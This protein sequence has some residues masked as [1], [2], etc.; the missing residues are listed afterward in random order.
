MKD[1][2]PDKEV[3]RQLERETDRLRG[4]DEFFALKLSIIFSSSRTAQA[5]RQ[6]KEL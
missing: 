5:V 6:R 1:D 4:C 3:G 2:I